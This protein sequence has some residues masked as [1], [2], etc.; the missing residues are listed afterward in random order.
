M[1]NLSYIY[2][3]LDKIQNPSPQV[4]GG[5][6]RALQFLLVVDEFEVKYDHK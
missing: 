6:K 5:I 1:V 4:C 2:P 3:S